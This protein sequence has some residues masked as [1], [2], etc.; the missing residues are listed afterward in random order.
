M[1]TPIARHPSSDPGRAAIPSAVFNYR[2]HITIILQIMICLYLKTC[3]YTNVGLIFAF[4]LT[5]LP[6]WLR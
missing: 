5:H 3:R 4:I 1:S 6:V 2:Y